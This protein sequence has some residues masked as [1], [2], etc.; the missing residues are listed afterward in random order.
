MLPRPSFALAFLACLAAAAPA[1]A[2]KASRGENLL[3]VVTPTAGGTARAHP[4]VNV[5]ARFRSARG[6]GPDPTTFRAKLGRRDVTALFAD[7]VENGVVTGKRAELANHLLHVGHGVNRLRLTVRSAATGKRKRLRDV[8]RI[9]FRA[10][11]APN[12]A[13]HAQASATALVVL[14]HVP[15]TF[16]A[17]GSYDPDDD[18]LDYRWDFGDGTTSTEPNPTKI[19]GDGVTDVVVTLTV[20]DREQAATDQEQLFAMCPTAPGRTF[21]T[22]RVEA[23]QALEL[24]AVP[25]GG[26]STATI[27]VK[28]VSNDPASQ[29]CVRLGTHGVST[30]STPFSVSPAQIDDIPAGG[31]A[32]VTLTFAPGATGHFPGGLT[33]VASST[34]RQVVHLL[35]HGY[36]GAAAGTGPTFAPEPFYSNVFGGGTF[37]VL[38]NGQRVQIDNTLLACQTPDGFGTRDLC[39]TNADCVNPGEVC[40]PGTASQVEPIDMCSDGAG[41]LYILSDEG[42]FSQPGDDGDLSVTLFQI[43]LDG[44]LQRVGANIV[45]RT[46]AQSYDLACDRRPAHDL[47]VSRYVELDENGNCRE[48]WEALDRVSTPGGAATTLLSPIDKAVGEDTCNGDID[49]IGDLQ[50]TA[51]GKFG[52]FATFQRRGGLFRIAGEGPTPLEIIQFIDDSFAVHPDGSILYAATHDVGTNGSIRLYKVSPEHAARSGPVV[53][54]DYSPCAIFTF[55]N[56]QGFTRLGENSI[57][58]TRAAPG[59]PDAVV[60]V[61]FRAAEGA[62][63]VRGAPLALFRTVVP[64]G[65]VAF[66][67]PAGDAP[68]TTLGLINVEQLDPLTF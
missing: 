59:S 4:F 63:P 13:P 1:A 31:E 8:D 44:A 58:A 22:L 41:S 18:A 39:A 66:A 7:V 30:G 28:N 16:D 6:V 37:A 45:Q 17:R 42:T 34:N 48:E 53:L 51:S 23:P 20:S 32:Q 65:T 2:A 57:A 12:Q 24:G 29:L 19:Y 54:D 26:A 67:V 21:G 68:C 61:S 14:P 52:A 49:E 38:P 27:V 55:P 50:V 64:Q 43:H 3:H 11:D 46:T 47:Y 35:A 9:R 60:L 15:V 10:I 33:L 25:E 40:T 62:P 36:G 56:N 5:V